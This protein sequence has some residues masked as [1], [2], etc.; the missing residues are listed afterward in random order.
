MNPI[1][2]LH[3]YL[4]PSEQRDLALDCDVCIYGG[5]SGGVIAAIAA[6]RRGLSVAL[7]EPGRHVGGL[8]VGGLTLT[9][10]GNKQAIGGLSREFYRRVGRKYGKEEFWTF[11]PHV[12]AEVFTEWL[13]EAGVECHFGS[14][15]AEVEMKDGRIR[16]ITTEHGLAVTARMFIDAS[17]EGDLMARAGVSFTVGREANATYG[18]TWN[19]SQVLEKHQFELPVD[20]HVVEGDP[21]SGLLPGIDPEPHVPGAGDARVQAYNFRLCLTDVAEN[22]LA[23]TEPAGYRREDYE[24]LARYCRAGFVP[25]F[26][27]FDGLIHGKVDANNHGAVSTDFIGANHAFPE[28]DYAE[29]ERIFQTH[30]AWVKGLLWFWM[31]D[32]AVPKVFQSRLRAWG[33]CRDEFIGTGGF[34]HALYVREARRLVGDLVMTEHH[35]TGAQ[36]AEEPVALAA[37]T[38]DSHNCRRVVLDGVVR[39]EGNVEIASGP[40]YPIGWRAIVPRRGECANLLVP[41]CLSA[42]HIA[43]GSIRMEPVFMILAEAAVEGAALA[44]EKGTAVQEVPYAELRERLLRAG[45]IVEPVADVRDRQRGE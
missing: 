24:L 34:S 32:P 21:A 16:R 20:P 44:L 26:Q 11:E 17:Y 37:Y 41:F 39:N 9:D 35:C 19:G 7:L 3:Y 6:K 22:R 2:G 10:I 14:F 31:S 18:E 12:A 30:V 1:A 45:Q 23:F 28:A 5:N 40:P 8:T 33:F 15:L 13:A 42:S 43:F 4:P 25:S 29:R 36:R 38:M 27:K